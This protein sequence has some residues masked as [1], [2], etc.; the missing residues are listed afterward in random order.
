M[1]QHFEEGKG[2]NVDRF[3]VVDKVRIIL[4]LVSTDTPS[5]ACVSWLTA[6]GAELLN[7]PM[8]LA[9]ASMR[10]SRS[11]ADDL[12]RRAQSKF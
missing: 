5:E 10:L 6:P 1:S 4:K 11:M 9:E 12:W 7:P 3:R 2:R 8:L